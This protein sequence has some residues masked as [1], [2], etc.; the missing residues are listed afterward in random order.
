[1]L[2]TPG[3]LFKKMNTKS[4][5]HNTIAMATEPQRLLFLKTLYPG[6]TRTRVFCSRGKCDVDCATSPRR[7]VRTPYVFMKITGLI[8][9][10]TATTKFVLKIY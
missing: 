7:K 1:L 10:V 5:I 8:S 2:P 9:R 6:G 4:I 3:N